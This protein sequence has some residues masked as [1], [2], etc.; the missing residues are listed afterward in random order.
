MTERKHLCRTAESSIRLRINALE[1]L[2][3]RSDFGL[4]LSAAYILLELPHHGEA[5][6][7]LSCTQ[8]RQNQ[9]T[10]RHVEIR[11]FKAGDRS[12]GFRK[13]AYNQER[14]AIQ[15]DE[16]SDQ[17]RVAMKSPLPISM[18]EDRYAGFSFSCCFLG[19]EYPAKAWVHSSRLEKIGGYGKAICSLEVVIGAKVQLGVP[20]TDNFLEDPA[21]SEVAVVEIR[22]LIAVS[23]LDSDKTIKVGQCRFEQKDRAQHHKENQ[24]YAR[25][26]TERHRTHQDESRALGERS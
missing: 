9:R 15:T 18:T 20:K 14:C 19:C 21:V 6:P 2:P 25:S 5:I 3:E 13:D 4:H 12:I 8:V 1:F 10:Q 23:R 24:V 17:I 22:Q 11:R 26:Q 7:I 16:L